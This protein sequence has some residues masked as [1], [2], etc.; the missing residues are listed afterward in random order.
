[1]YMR[2][3]CTLQFAASYLILNFVGGLSCSK[4]THKTNSQWANV[5]SLRRSAGCT[6]FPRYGFNYGIYGKL[7]RKL[8]PETISIIVFYCCFSF[9]NV[10]LCFHN[11]RL[12]LKPFIIEATHD[13][14]EPEILPELTHSLHLSHS[15]D[16]YVRKIE[17]RSLQQK[18]RSM[19]EK[20]NF[21]RK[22]RNS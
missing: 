9:I 6:A 21:A 3:K 16:I 1:M 12:I 20:K 17:L 18:D 2:V 11:I 4:I 14:K 10:I 22:Q 8:A 15:K 5:A 7:K 19:S 13:V